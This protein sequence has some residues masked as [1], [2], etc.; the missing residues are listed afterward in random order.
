MLYAIIIVMSVEDH[1]K[2]KQ[3]TC[4][5]EQIILVE[6]NLLCLKYIFFL[7]ALQPIVGFYFA[8]L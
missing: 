8:A 1:T 5:Q 2:H 6:D 4:R 7:L 3:E